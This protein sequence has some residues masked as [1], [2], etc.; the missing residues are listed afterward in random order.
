MKSVY[1]L[2]CN[3]YII[4]HILIEECSRIQREYASVLSSVFFSYNFGIRAL[5]WAMVIK[6][7]VS[8]AA[9]TIFASQPLMIPIFSIEKYEF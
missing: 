7:S 4:D 8:M 2:V 1:V 3:A 6:N 9:N 5:D